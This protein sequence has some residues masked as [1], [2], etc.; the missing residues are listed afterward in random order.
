[1]S[2]GA[3][4]APRRRQ[5][6]GRNWWST[7]E[8]HRRPNGRATG[9][10]LHCGFVLGG[11]SMGGQI[12]MECHHLFPERIRALVLAWNAPPSS[13]PSS[14][15]SWQGRL[16]RRGRRA[17]ARSP[18]PWDARCGASGSERL[19][20]PSIHSGGDEECVR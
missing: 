3:S 5:R 19:Q 16:S 20:A 13:T 9:A 15:T 1:M 14:R 17:P 7:A 2:S 18:R 4:D 8:P 10:G 12:V 6:G 11:L